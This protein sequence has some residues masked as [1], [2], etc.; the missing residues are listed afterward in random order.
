MNLLQGLTLVKFINMEDCDILN[1][2][3]DKYFEYVSVMRSY[4][5]KDLSECYPYIVSSEAME[6]IKRYLS[7]K[8]VMKKVNEFIKQ[9]NEPKISNI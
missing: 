2:E 7:N 8:R 6:I 9:K 1:K 3:F 5:K 4:Y